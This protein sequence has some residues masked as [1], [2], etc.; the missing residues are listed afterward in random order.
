MPGDVD[1]DR[2]CSPVA[3]LDQLPLDR[4]RRIPPTNDFRGHLDGS[5]AA[6]DELPVTLIRSPRSQL[7]ECLVESLCDDAVRP[8]AAQWRVL[9]FSARKPPHL[10]TGR[11][12]WRSRRRSACLPQTPHET[13]LESSPHVAPHRGPGPRSRLN[14]MRSALSDASRL[15]CRADSRHKPSR[16][17]AITAQYSVQLPPCIII[18]I[19]SLVALSWRVYTRLICV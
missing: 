6:F 11:E 3:A 16:S 17:T 8:S 2:R 5:L 9:R 14:E 4:R 1:V 12:P 10:A 13:D 19:L 15:S 7:S 18:V